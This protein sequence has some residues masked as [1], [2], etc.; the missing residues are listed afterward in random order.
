MEKI[1]I[2][3]R[4]K[5]ERHK[6][7]LWKKDP[8][9]FE[10]SKVSVNNS[11]VTRPVDHIGSCT[12][13]PNTERTVYLD[14]YYRGSIKMKGK[15]RVLTLTESENGNRDVSHFV[16][17]YGNSVVLVFNRRARTFSEIRLLGPKKYS[18]T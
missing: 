2:T 15:E 9:R 4:I 5:G 6:Y 13:R 7:F 18:S 10:R 8:D 12:F 14:F 3:T 11:P 17:D 16:L 1:E